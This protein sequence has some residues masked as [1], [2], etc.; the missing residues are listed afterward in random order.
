MKNF[1]AG[2]ANDKSF[3]APTEVVN[4]YRA[5]SK[6]LLMFFQVIRAG[7]IKNQTTLMSMLYKIEQMT[8]YNDNEKNGVRSAQIRFMCALF[9]FIIIFIIIFYRESRVQWNLLIEG[10]YET[11][12]RDFVL[13]HIRIT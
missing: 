4:S 11:Q 8:D 5:I 7:V 12:I 10:T 9:V 6:N 2:K 3:N 13:R 1:F